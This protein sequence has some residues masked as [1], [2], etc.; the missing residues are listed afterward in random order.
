MN[1]LL[2]VTFFSRFLRQSFFVSHTDFLFAV[3]FRQA[4]S[5]DCFDCQNCQ[6]P[7]NNQTS[8]ATCGTGVT[9]CL[10]SF[11]HEKKHP[12]MRVLPRRK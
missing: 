5:I 10:V 1:A 8:T 2:I 6:T 4:M 12:S 3:F 7:Y 9:Q 11:A